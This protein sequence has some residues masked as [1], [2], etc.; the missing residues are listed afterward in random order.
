M[1]DN[2]LFLFGT[3]RHSALLELVADGPVDGEPAI[4]EN[5]AV[6]FAHDAT[7]PRNF[8]VL[9]ESDGAQV[10]GQLITPNPTQ[11]ARL[12][13]YERIF[14]YDPQPAT[15]I[16]QTGPVEALIYR[17]KPGRYQG[18][19]PWDLDSWIAQYGA[20]NLEAAADLMRFLD[21]ASP[22]QLQA[23]HGM[24]E[25]RTASRRRARKD[26]T[27]AK[28]RRDP[29]VDKDVR[30][31]DH[32]RPYSLFFGVEETD[33]QFRRFDGS[34]SDVVKRAGFIMGDAV[35]VLP[36]DPVRDRVML[37]EQFRYGPYARG[38]LNP[39]SLEPIAGRIDPH[40]TPQSAVRREAV[41]ET[42]LDLAELLPVARY[43]VSPGAVT[44]YLFSYIGIAD[45]PDT[46]AGIGGLES[47]AEDIQAHIISFDQ[48]MELLETNEAEN[49]PL[50]ISAQWLALNRDRLRAEQGAS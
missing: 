38:D 2:P 6:Q 8:P 41:E 16:T 33:L 35:T 30:V 3:L 20:F 25:V 37:V 15:V 26:R 49:G 1:P 28:L 18:G 32:K 24:V 17:P 12:D 4:L 14:G 13:T 29:D 34:F 19:A 42:G 43:Y 22:E 11:R 45:L 9:I 5:H 50:L 48:L 40:E 21:Y 36:Y 27:P 7:G 47:E 10:A 44:E 23:G 46:A 31:A 39:W